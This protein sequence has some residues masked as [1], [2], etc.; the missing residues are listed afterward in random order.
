MKKEIDNV[1]RIPASLDGKFFQYWLEFL[2]PFHNLTNREIEV[3]AQIIKERYNLSKVIIDNEMVDKVLLSEET[4]RKI[5]TE[6]NVSVAY[7]QVIMTKLRESRIFI[8]GKLNPKFIPNLSKDPK[9]F[10]LL[11]YFEL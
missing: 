2:R 7:F 1:I 8:N 3:A 5:R 4:K 10:K 9:D 6:C 11:L